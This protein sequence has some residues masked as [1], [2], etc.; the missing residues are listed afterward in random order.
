[1]QRNNTLQMTSLAT[2]LILLI[3]M[4]VMLPTT[5]NWNATYSQQL[6]TKKAATATIVYTNPNGPLTAKQQKA[7]KTNENKLAANQKFLGFRSLESGNDT[8]AKHRLNSA[9]KST[10]LSILH[11]KKSQSQFHILIPQL[12]NLAQ[13]AGV[14]TYITGSDVLTVARAQSVQA[15]NKLA[16]IISCILS[17]LI[18]GGIFRSFVAPLIALLLSGI[19]YL[20]SFSGILLATRFLQ[21]PYS[22]YSNTG[23][24]VVCFG[25]FPIAI[26]LF[27]QALGRQQRAYARRAAQFYRETWLIS[28]LS[29][30]PVILISFMGLLAHNLLLSSLWGFGVALV[31]SWLVFYTLMPALTAFLDDL[32]FWPENR[33]QPR[34]HGR[35][36]ESIAHLGRRH[37][38]IGLVCLFLLLGASLLLVR[39]TL[40]SATDADVS[41]S[42][43][44][45]TGNAAIASHYPN[46][47]SAPITLKLTA[48]KPLTAAQRLA[49]ID[50]LTKKLKAVPRVANVY[51]LTQP[52]G[53]AL[54]QLYVNHQLQT[55][56]SQ[57][58]AANLN[59]ANTQKSLKKS[60]LQLSKLK[61]SASLKQL[62][63]N[64]SNLT[65]IQ[66]Q[67]S[68]VASQA[69]ALTT[70]IE[71]IEAQETDITQ[72]LGASR[73][74]K[75]IAAALTMH[76]KKLV[77]DLKVLRENI[78]V[79]SSNNDVIA[80][81]I[82]QV[83]TD[84]QAVLSDFKAANSALKAT[85]TALTQDS[86][87]VQ[88]AQQ[89][90][91]SDRRYLDDLSK[92][93][94]VNT[95]YMTD[96]D[97]KTGP[98]KSALRQFNQQKNKTTTFVIVLNTAPATR[99]AQTTLSQLQSVTDATLSTTTLAH[100]QTQFDGETVQVSKQRHRFS[101]D[102]KWLLPI[103]LLIV[104][105]Y[106]F[107]LA[108]SLF[109]L[110]VSF[111]LFISATVGLILANWLSQILFK[112]ALLVP[113]PLLA[114]LIFLTI[115]FL[116]GTPLVLQVNP[117]VAKSLQTTLTTFDPR[118]TLG[119]LFS[120]IL[121]L[122]LSFTEALS[123]IQL[124]LSVLIML[125]ICGIC[126]PFGLTTASQLT[127]RKTT[128]KD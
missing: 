61:L 107:I 62:S 108:R 82:S 75:R 25:L 13:T 30:L 53:T 93:G 1:M 44:A 113:V 81:N 7:I 77:H 112:S 26:G 84:Q 78:Q 2:W 16:I 105:L 54:T 23:L 69:S 89:N 125:V 14:K 18:L 67:N 9:D 15:A 28:C 34:F 36:W 21:T 90:L 118:L 97:L 43:Q 92:S 66:T 5:L 86:K 100:S 22:S 55:Q 110:Y 68:Q 6:P 4:V 119:S 70:D 79:I 85:K 42:S 64:D 99:A 12:Y 117:A 88:T 56:A 102:I 91:A 48:K 32:L 124:A 45:K 116:M 71:T 17:A 59:L 40:N 63:K 98:M 94:V 83:E 20:V 29:L 103:M 109:S 120:L 41:F 51:S 123:F 122:S 8:N 106:L 10:E 39:P 115:G 35:L 52:G 60:R 76:Q 46:G 121:L 104:G 57:L 38:A 50:Q 65:K 73:S 101:Q 128:S 47:K 96:N 72:L 114:T 24:I 111:G 49:V 127:Y 80:E 31:S 58:S 11:F 19:S 27:Y 95:L 126:L 87:N 37:A 74:T 3:G 33:F